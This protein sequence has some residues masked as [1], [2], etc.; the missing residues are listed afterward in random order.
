M[1]AEIFLT[2]AL[3]SP[4][5]NFTHPPIEKP[6][7]AV[8]DQVKKEIQ[9]LTDFIRKHNPDAEVFI[10]PKGDAERLKEYGWEKV[11]FTW[12][13]QEIWIQRKPKSDQYKREIQE[14][15]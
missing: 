1:I 10:T 13:D 8:Q 14:G 5:V 12:R 7:F 2:C 15:A 3:A 9:D 11:P 6:I 4:A